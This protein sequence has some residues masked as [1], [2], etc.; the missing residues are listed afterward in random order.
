MSVVFDMIYYVNMDKDVERN[1][2]M[3]E[4]FKRCNITG[5]KRITGEVVDYRDVDESTYRNFNKK[6]V[7]YLNGALG[8][9][10]SH[11]NLV[12][13][14]KKNNYERVLILEDDVWWDPELDL[15]QLLTLNYWNIVESDM[16]YFGGLV[17]QHM[18]NQ[19][20]CTHAFSL[21]KRTYDDILNM[22]EASGMEIDNFY[23]KV[24]QHMSRND[25]PQGKYTI[26]QA[27][28]FNI[29]QQNA[30]FQSNIQKEL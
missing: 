18:R 15:N 25:R 29:F 3:I 2:Y 6:D 14:A 26:N 16:C 7:K 23:A 1:E 11:I 30:R 17:E 9:R 21:N 19:I 27:Y 12:R 8:C 28:P 4:H 22:C 20:V 13:D 24:L 5:Y 10:L